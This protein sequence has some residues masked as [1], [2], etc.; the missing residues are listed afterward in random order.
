MPSGSLLEFRDVNLQTSLPASGDE[1][2]LYTPFRDGTR[3]Y[4]TLPGG[5]R[6]GFTFRPKAVGLFDPYQRERDVGPDFQPGNGLRAVYF[7][8]SFVADN[9]GDFHF[10]S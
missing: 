1:P 5:Q 8:P 6:E 10:F 3:V 9:D 4:V 7:V 2:D